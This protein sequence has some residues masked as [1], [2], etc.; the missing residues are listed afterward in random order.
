MTSMADS[1]ERTLSK[2]E[3]RAKRRQDA[4]DEKAA[5]QSQDVRK[6]PGSADQGSKPYSRPRPKNVNIAYL[7]FRVAVLKKAQYVEN[8]T[9][10]AQK[11]GRRNPEASFKTKKLFALRDEVAIKAEKLNQAR[12]LNRVER[13]DGGPLPIKREEIFGPSH[14][15]PLKTFK[16]DE[17][18]LNHNRKA[19]FSK[20]NTRQQEEEN[21]GFKI[22]NKNSRQ[23][24]LDK[25]LAR[26]GFLN[27]NNGEH[28]NGD[29]MGEVEAEVAEWCYRAI[30]CY[31][32]WPL[33]RVED[34]RPRR[35]RAVGWCSHCMRSRTGFVACY[36]SQVFQVLMGT[37]RF[38]VTYLFKHRC[39]RCTANQSTSRSTDETVTQDTFTPVHYTASSQLN[40]ANGEWTG[41]DDLAAKMPSKTPWNEIAAG[42]SRD[43]V[44]KEA[45]N[46][47]F[48]R[49]TQN[50][51][52]IERDEVVANPQPAVCRKHLA[53]KC[54]YGDK[55][56]Y[57]HPPLQ[58]EEANYPEEKSD[59]GQSVETKEEPAEVQ[60]QP[61]PVV[62]YDPDIFDGWFDGENGADGAP[63]D[64]YLSDY[65]GSI[66]ED[67]VSEG[68]GFVMQHSRGKHRH[69]RELKPCG[70]IR[71]LPGVLSAVGASFPAAEY[72]V[73]AAADRVLIKEFPG[74]ETN[75]ALMKAMYAC[76][77][78]NFPMVPNDWLTNT[79]RYYTHKRLVS[80]HEVTQG[81]VAFQ[82]A[83]G[84]PSSV[85]V[86]TRNSLI[87]YNISD[88]RCSIE[89]ELDCECTI[90]RTWE[91]RSDYVVRRTTYENGVSH[92]V[93]LDLSPI[94]SEDGGLTY[95]DEFF[96][97]GFF[98]PGHRTILCR[99]VGANQRPFVRYANSTTN[100]SKALKRLLASRGPMEQGLREH[101]SYLGIMYAKECG[102]S[103]HIVKLLEVLR[104]KPEAMGYG[105]DIWSQY[106]K[107]MDEDI[108]AEGDHLPETMPT[109]CIGSRAQGTL[110][111]LEPSCPTDF[112][113]MLTRVMEF[114]STMNDRCTPAFLTRFLDAAKT[115][116]NW[117]YNAIGVGLL[118]CLPAL[119]SRARD[120]SIVHTKRQLRQE[121]YN[122]T[123]LHL[124]D[125]VL[126]QK[127][128]LRVK[129][130]S[131]K[132]AKVPRLFADYN[133]GCIYASYLPALA[134]KLINGEYTFEHKGVLCILNV[135]SEPAADGI[136]TIFDKIIRANNSRDELY[137]AVYSDDV[138]LGG[139][140]RGRK[141]AANI[142]I[143]SCDSSNW[144]PIFLIVGGLLGNISERRA[145][146]LVEQCCKPMFAQNPGPEKEKIEVI[147]SSA[148]EGSG[149]VL[150]T[151]LN[152]VASGSG[153]IAMMYQL[154]ENE[155]LQTFGSDDIASLR[156]AAKQGFATVGHVVTVDPAM[157]H[158]TVER[159]KFQF[160]KRSY[161][162]TTT[163][164]FV[165]F[166]NYGAIFRN[167]GVFD[168]DLE[169][170]SLNMGRDE[171]N[172]LNWSQRFEC[173]ARGV[174]AGLVHE[175]SSRIMDALRRRFQ[176]TEA[177]KPIFVTNAL[178]QI[179]SDDR[180]LH[181]LDSLAFMERYDVSED[182]IDELVQQI[183][184]Q[185]F[186]GS[187][188]TSSAV[189]K[190]FAVD[191]GV[192]DLDSEPIAVGGAALLVP[193]AAR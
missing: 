134:K 80:L 186:A 95:P 176:P 162:L 168:G 145:Q 45:K 43:R 30:V 49:K 172:S 7:E 182:E 128:Q 57:S 19:E 39:C 61:V 177:D 98:K 81:N 133:K 126:I 69:K 17:S 27:G 15:P 150:T 191:Y 88:Q 8:N 124:E 67:V 93:K 159:A 180:H 87:R 114:I 151:L 42:I 75:L 76:L 77:Q 38:R 94:V 155:Y 137:C 131:G 104:V 185:C 84:K 127:V 68:H 174:V 179:E 32:N 83:T 113:S 184:N 188:L 60:T 101:Q 1:S 71:S 74:G 82:A 157:H 136:G 58:R 154:I 158:G 44:R 86:V 46:K 121:Y 173:Y 119:E 54:T 189:A 10:P 106:K 16:K 63:P 163:N 120:V 70:Y 181:E 18:E 107:Y 125:D 91:P 190:F 164:R 50:R 92:T 13:P 56:K 143:S 100:I 115:K 193:A 20:K 167:F 140:I 31:E 85:D 142:D 109:L 103:P 130:E 79:V 183:E 5:A 6:V 35:E 28:T 51:D 89:K 29:D 40:G 146:G 21:L 33:Q 118:E 62:A 129:M 23:G 78:K 90:N 108:E 47:Q 149:T 116:G 178:E 53:G 9:Y 147:F 48:Q 14:Y 4:L 132:Y 122:S 192:V 41:L 139:S 12:E 64:H 152:F 111:D 36:R 156:Y 187:C 135:Y 52:L 73:F 153:G 166:L 3:R 148:F 99:F 175:P 160:L 110:V 105:D 22:K 170:S 112:H 123:P 66:I 26:A 59:R 72:Q 138:I 2:A 96:V 144:W 171:F 97:N 141:F 102:F 165:E 24:R 55:C 37:V 65:A 117:V 11:Q 34:F 25:K 169:P 161:G